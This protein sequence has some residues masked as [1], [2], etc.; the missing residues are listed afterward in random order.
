MP[1]Y[2]SHP[3]VFTQKL[4]PAFLFLSGQ[5]NKIRPTF[6]ASKHKGPLPLTKP[7]QITLNFHI[8][9]LTESGHFSPS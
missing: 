8:P 9:L 1:S 7:V 2:H 5:F 3:T 4:S 6:S